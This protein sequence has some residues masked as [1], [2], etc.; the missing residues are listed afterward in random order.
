[1][2][3]IAIVREVRSNSLLVRDLATGQNVIV[4][5]NT[6]RRFCVGDRI[7]IWFNGVMT[8]SIPPQINAIRIRRIFSSG[9]CR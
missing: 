2:L 3:M 4:R 7:A 6:A 5:T 1:M 9:R 8:R